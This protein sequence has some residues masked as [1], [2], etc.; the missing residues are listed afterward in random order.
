MHPKSFVIDDASPSLIIES[1]AVLEGAC[2]MSTE[3]ISSSKK[4]KLPP[5]PEVSS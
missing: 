5:R 4:L 1:G 3:E 2:N